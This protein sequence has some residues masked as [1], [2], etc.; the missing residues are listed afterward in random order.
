MTLIQQAG[1][2]QAGRRRPWGKIVLIVLAGLI[3]SPLPFRTFLFHPFNMPSGSMTPTLQVG[4]MFFVAK[5]SYGY[6]HYSLPFSPNLFSGRI[7]GSAPERGD[8]VV[9]R[10]PKDDRID[11]VKRVV[12]LPGDL[13]QVKQ[14]QLYINGT[15]VARERGQDFVGNDPCGSGPATATRRW[16]ETLPNGVSY[17]TLDCV[18]NGFYDNTN[19]YTVPPGHFFVLGDNRDNSV[20][21]RVLSQM[22]YI[23]L[24]NVIGRVGLI[25]FS[26]SPSGV[27]RSERIG[28]VVR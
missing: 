23:P 16:R 9:F 25:F 17:E 4:D 11:F 3:L 22:G 13:V 7:F 15:A 19:V 28:T 18:A 14:G 26:K 5:Y 6:S 10:S 24:E 1:A 21:S 2:Q 12:G 27:T 20:D 8:V